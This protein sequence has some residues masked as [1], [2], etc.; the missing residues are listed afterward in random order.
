MAY[1]STQHRPSTSAPGDGSR[2]LTL[3]AAPPRQEDGESSNSPDDPSALGALR[4]RGASRAHRPR[5]A[6]DEDVVD[7]EG[8]GRKS[9]KS[10]SSLSPSFP[11][12][13]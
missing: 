12:V 11:R 2:T 3:T 5:V 4:L 1:I 6:W 7:N 9:S 13:A 10:A 8:C